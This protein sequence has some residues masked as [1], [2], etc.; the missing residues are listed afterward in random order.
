MM[1]VR[2]PTTPGA[3]LTAIPIGLL[4]AA[5]ASE[6]LRPPVLLALGGAFVAAWWAYRGDDAGAGAWTYI[7]G[8]C[9]LA[10]MSLAWTGVDLPA[11]ARDGSTCANPLAPF[12]AYRAVGA[13]LVLTAVA[14]VMRLLGLT[15]ATIGV[16]RASAGGLAVA[17]GALVAVGVFA[18]L[19]GP[20]LA[21]PFFGPL[22]VQMGDPAALVPAL[23][24][25]IANASMEETVYR[26]VLLRGLMRSRSPVLALGVQAIVFGLAH[27]VGSDFSGS[28]LPVIAA[29]A[30]GGL[31]F[32]AVALRT[33]SLLV[34]VALHAALDIPIYYANAC[35]QVLR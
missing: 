34:P 28:P 29:T 24:F 27:G 25:A 23:L 8:A 10:T 7:T 1:T 33:G 21:E 26:G 12:A 18:A 3:A 22:P 32:G 20:A 11:T 14:V 6:A 30:V 15:A 13:V 16:R 19:I 2:S 9:L 31:A 5:A 17:L 4:L 35:L